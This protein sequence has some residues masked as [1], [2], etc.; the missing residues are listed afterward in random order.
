[1]KHIFLTGEIQIGKSTVIQKTLALL[2][3]DYGGFQTYFSLDRGAA[4]RRLYIS[5]A[6]QA[7]RFDEHSVIAQFH[8]HGQLP[9]VFAERFDTLGTR[10]I[11]DAA[12]SARL[13][14]MDELGDLEREALGFQ[15]AVLKVLEGDLSILGVIRK[16]ALGWVD[17]VRRHP[18]VI[19]ITVDRDNRDA[20]PEQLA[21]T[22][23]SA[24]PSPR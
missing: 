13:I 15:I 21:Q 11:L 4:D 7:L 14:V 23:R 12:R 24:L 18:D 8:R 5:R 17:Q 9:Q 3:V 2:D 1:M 19:L 10:Y 20:L 16:Q 22:L 6:G